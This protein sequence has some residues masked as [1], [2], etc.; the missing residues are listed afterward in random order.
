M[1]SSKP[2][3][4]F[5]HSL[6]KW[7]KIFLSIDILP[8]SFVNMVRPFTHTAQPV[9]VPIIA[10][11]EYHRDNIQLMTSYLVTTRSYSGLPEKLLLI[12]IQ[13]SSPLAQAHIHILGTQQLTHIYSNLQHPMIRQ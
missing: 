1:P 12:W 5:K 11:F 3:N 8:H 10:L 9:T 4:I 6:E 7:G 2:T 13:S